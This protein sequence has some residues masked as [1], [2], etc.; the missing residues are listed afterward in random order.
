MEPLATADDL[1]RRYR[2]SRAT[3]LAWRRRG[4]IPA[5]CASRRPVLFD[6]DDVEAALRRRGTSGDPETGGGI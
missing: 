4:I 2:V 5:I 1:S 3:I 6:P